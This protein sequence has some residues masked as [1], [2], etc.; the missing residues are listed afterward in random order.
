MGIMPNFNIGKY[1]YSVIIDIILIYMIIA[2]SVIPVGI[3]SGVLFG[4]ID[5]NRLILLI[6]MDLGVIFYFYFIFLFKRTG[7]TVAMKILKLRVLSN[8]N[9]KYL[10][11]QQ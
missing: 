3:I 6:M 10:L 5:D 9:K 7:Q 1:F 4:E 2:F 11:L 8:K